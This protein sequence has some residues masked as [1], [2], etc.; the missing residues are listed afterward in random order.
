[1][2]WTMVQNKIDDASVWLD[3]ASSVQASSFGTRYWAD[4]IHPEGTS[5]SSAMNS[6]AFF[7]WRCNK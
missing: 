5:R 2:F 6:R 4:N 3:E 7:A 1:M